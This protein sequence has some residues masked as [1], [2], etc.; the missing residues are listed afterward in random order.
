MF[1]FEYN[2]LIDA[3]KRIFI[4]FI[5]LVLM[6]SNSLEILW[7][8]LMVGLNLGGKFFGSYRFIFVKVFDDFF[9]KFDICIVEIIMKSIIFNIKYDILYFLLDMVFIYN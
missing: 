3:R 8:K 9:I 1:N 5:T 7:I 6:L 2:V 4:N